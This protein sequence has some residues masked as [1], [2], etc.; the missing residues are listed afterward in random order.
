M[1]K[2]FWCIWVNESD[3]EKENL[4]RLPEY[5]AL[6]EAAVAASSSTKN[7]KKGVCKRLRVESIL[8]FIDSGDTGEKVD[9][10]SGKVSVSEANKKKKTKDSEG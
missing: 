6:R 5:Q 8:D 4:G 3:E 1:V 7:R 10:S 2:K 9:D